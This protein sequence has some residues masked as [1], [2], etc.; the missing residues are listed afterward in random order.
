MSR[1]ETRT[2]QN[3]GENIKNYGVIIAKEGVGVNNHLE[4]KKYYSS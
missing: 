4:N 3:T 2:W 1:L